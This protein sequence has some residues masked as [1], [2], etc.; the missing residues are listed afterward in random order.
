[1]IAAEYVLKFSYPFEEETDAELEMRK[2]SKKSGPGRAHVH[3]SMAETEKDCQDRINGIADCIYN[4]VR[5]R[6]DR[7]VARPPVPVKGGKAKRARRVTAWDIFKCE[8]ASQKHLEDAGGIQA[9]TAGAH[10]A[11]QNLTT[12][13]RGA[14]D[15]R[16][17]EEQMAREREATQAVKPS[18]ELTEEEKKEKEKTFARHVMCIDGTVE[19]T[20]KSWHK[21]V[22]MVSLILFGCVDQYGELVAGI[23]PVQTKM[24]IPS[25]GA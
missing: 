12:V 16:A 4:W 22:G 20:L 23:A 15:T 1:M 24:A 13:Q 18:K 2:A 5:N 21:M 25:N 14:Y 10:A 9:W 3:R 6:S 7:R 11:F 8:R 19:E 17:Y